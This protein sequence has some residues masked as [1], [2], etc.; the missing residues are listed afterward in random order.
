MALAYYNEILDQRYTKYVNTPKDFIKVLQ[1]N[2]FPSQEEIITNSNL[3][4]N[5]G[6][7]NKLSLVMKNINVNSPIR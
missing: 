6:F 3:Y 7:K 2:S 5:R 1:S 4:I